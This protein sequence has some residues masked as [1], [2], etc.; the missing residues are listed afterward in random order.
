MSEST[1][2]KTEHRVLCDQCG[3]CA[4]LVCTDYGYLCSRCAFRQAETDDA[5]DSFAHLSPSTFG[6]DPAEEW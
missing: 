6:F 1:A 2:P 4:P 3:D 5:R